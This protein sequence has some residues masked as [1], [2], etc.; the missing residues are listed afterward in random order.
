MLFDPGNVTSDR[1]KQNKNLCDIKFAYTVYCR[2]VRFYADCPDY[3]PVD[4]GVVTLT[5]MPA[6]N[7]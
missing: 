5:L 2:A 3:Q 6:P 4:C 7:T 1:T